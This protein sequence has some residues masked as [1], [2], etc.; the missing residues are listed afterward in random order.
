MLSEKVKSKKG[1]APAAAPNES[2]RSSDGIVVL[3]RTGTRHRESLRPRRE[4]SRW[5]SF[6]TTLLFS[7]ATFRKNVNRT[8]TVDSR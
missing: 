2:G 5:S 8:L 6:T 1:P 7:A 3:E 4:A